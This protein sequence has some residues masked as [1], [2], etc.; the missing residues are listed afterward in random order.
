MLISDKV[1]HLFLDNEL[2]CPGPFHP[3]GNSRCERCC[4][5]CCY[6]QKCPSK[7]HVTTGKITKEELRYQAF[8]NYFVYSL[9]RLIEL[10][11]RF[12]KPAFKKQPF[13]GVLKNKFS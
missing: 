5:K 7:I 10:F 11:K 9:N 4:V 2:R 6:K 1:K 8:F 12:T 3:N 13:R